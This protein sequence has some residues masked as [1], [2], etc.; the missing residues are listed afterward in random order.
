MMKRKSALM[1][2]YE[3]YVIKLHLRGMWKNYQRGF[4]SMSGHTP[5]F[6]PNAVSKVKTILEDFIIK[7]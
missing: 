7:G 4:I 5:W 2:V 1:V 3:Q 6:H